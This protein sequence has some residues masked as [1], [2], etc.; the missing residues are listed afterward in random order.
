M[1]ARREVISLPDDC[2]EAESVATLQFQCGP[3]GSFDQD[4]RIE[5]TDERTGDGKAVPEGL[6][7]ES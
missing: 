3:S 2:I 1:A 4:K 6:D 5:S 7:D